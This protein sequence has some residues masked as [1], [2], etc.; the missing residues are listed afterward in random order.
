MQRGC[1]DARGDIVS[2]SHGSLT[3]RAY[4]CPHEH[5]D[6]SSTSSYYRPRVESIS[7]KQRTYMGTCCGARVMQINPDSIWREAAII[8]ARN[9]TRLS[10]VELPVIAHACNLFFIFYDGASNVATIVERNLRGWVASNF[11]SGCQ[12]PTI[13][14]TMTKQQPAIE[15]G[16]FTPLG[17]VTFR[18]LNPGPHTQRLT[19]TSTQG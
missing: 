13:R 5:W 6:S 9:L 1:E 3:G 10:W 4:R 8:L 18:A 11:P 17:F 2:G 12:C 14:T 19:T 15:T 16:G 7:L